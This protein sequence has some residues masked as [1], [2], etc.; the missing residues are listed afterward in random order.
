MRRLLLALLLLAL[1][2][3]GPAL[4]YGW[5]VKP[6]DEPHPIRGFFDDPR[7]AHGREEL[8]RAFHFG[9]DI[10]APD[11]TPVYAVERGTVNRHAHNVA[12]TTAEGRIFGYWHIDPVVRSKELVRTHQL[13]GRVQAGWGH[14]HLAESIDGEYLNPLRFGGLEP[15]VDDTP[16]TIAAIM[17]LRDGRL[18]DI[19]HV[20]GVVD[21]EADAYDTPV[22]EPRGAWSSSRVTPAL[23]RWRVVA[24]L[25]EEGPW[26]VAADFRFVLLPDALFSLVYA[27]GTHENRAL[28]PGR[29]RFYLEQGFDTR[30]LPDGFYRLEVSAG[31]MRGNTTT[32]AL[33]FR[34]AHG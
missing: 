20:T 11:G 32:S 18:V 21:L 17:L 16:P 22:P 4:A 31:D 10:A 19:A 15:Y 2:A 3:P 33:P 13:L 14:V 8:S 30:S 24:G 28:R 26:H 12:V 29:Y 25:A 1:A 6:V 7:V 23:L 5:P 27:P 9:V 34:I